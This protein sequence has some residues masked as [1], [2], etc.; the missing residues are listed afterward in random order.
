M[1]TYDYECPACGTFEHFQSI[2]DAPLTKCPKCKKRK[3]HRLIST[4][5]GIIFKG[6][7]F[8]ETDYNRSSD[9]QKKTK[10]ETGTTTK[11]AETPKTET[12]PAATKSETKSE[13]KAETP[14]PPSKPSKKD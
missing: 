10:E 14:K 7:G 6:S 3:V 12:T 5:G 13:T 2:K 9:Y 11:P 8:W 4:G 1:P